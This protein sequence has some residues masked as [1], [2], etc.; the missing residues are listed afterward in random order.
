[1]KEIQESKELVAI[2][3][4]IHN[5]HTFNH[6]FEF[7][8]KQKR[9]MNEIDYLEV[10]VNTLSSEADN[11]NA[12]LDKL[13]KDLDIIE[14]ESQEHFNNNKNDSEKLLSEREL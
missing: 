13:E 6:H 11:L 12:Y 8:R 7:Y 5:S 10:I 4:E 3:N 2:L 14:I 9:I 1:M